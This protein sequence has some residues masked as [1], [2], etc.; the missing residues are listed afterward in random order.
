MPFCEERVT[1]A[2]MRL[3]SLESLACKVDPWLM[4][5]NLS[6]KDLPTIP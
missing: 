3:L 5:E 1:I 2:D 4:P 6:Y